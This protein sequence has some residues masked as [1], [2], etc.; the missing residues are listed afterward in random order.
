MSSSDTLACCCRLLPRRLRV[1][2]RGLDVLLRGVDVRLSFVP[3]FIERASEVVERC[4][5]RLS[6]GLC[7]LP[8]CIS[9]AFPCFCLA[10]AGLDVAPPFFRLP[11]CGFAPLG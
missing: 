10:L 9:V 4:L 7:L 11:G 3:R 2:P 5:G 1:P 8:S 6:P